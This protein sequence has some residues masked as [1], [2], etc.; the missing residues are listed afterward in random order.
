MAQN[1]RVDEALEVWREFLCNKRPHP[2]AFEQHCIPFG[3]IDSHDRS[4]LPA[5]INRYVLRAVEMDIAYADD[6][7]FTYV[8]MGPVAVL[9]FIELQHPKELPSSKVHV[10]QG[11]IGQGPYRLP[12]ALYLY[13]EE[14]ARKYGSINEQLSDR[15]RAIADAATVRALERDKDRLSNSH[16]LKAMQQDVD[17]FGD[18]AFEEGWPG[19]PER[20]K[21]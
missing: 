18:R 15:Q 3:T 21:N 2:A 7:S 5:N 11:T 19:R 9:G 10:N 20:D 6:F 16:W 17:L 13:W 1:P 4:R 12:P 8:K 14:R